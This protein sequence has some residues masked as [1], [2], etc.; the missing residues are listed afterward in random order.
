MVIAAMAP[1]LAVAAVAMTEVRTLRDQVDR[2]TAEL[3]D[4][5]GVVGYLVTRDLPTE[6]APSM[7]ADGQ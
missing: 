4:L 7:P 3:A 2:L 5:Q 6:Q 1:G